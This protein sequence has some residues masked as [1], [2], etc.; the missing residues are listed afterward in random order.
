MMLLLQDL[1]IYVYFLQLGG[2]AVGNEVCD[3]N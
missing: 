1:I 2:V 3:G